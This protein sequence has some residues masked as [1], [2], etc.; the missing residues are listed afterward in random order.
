MIERIGRRIYIA[1]PWQLKAQAR[2]W[3]GVLEAGGLTVTSRW[4][5]T[6]DVPQDTDASALE[7]LEDVIAADR[8]LLINPEAWAAA[9]TG[10]RHVEFGYAV[11]A[12]KD[13]HIFGVRSNVFHHLRYVTVHETVDHALAA[14]VAAWR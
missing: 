14:L 7:C 8:L 13:L 4:L 3:R 1:A 12:G 10:G 2:A 9:G 5:D 11:A 6:P